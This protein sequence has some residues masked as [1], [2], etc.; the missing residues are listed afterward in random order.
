MTIAIRSGSDSQ[1]YAGGSNFGPWAHGVPDRGWRPGP[2]WPTWRPL[3]AAT[4]ATGP[5]ADAGALPEPEALRCQ[6]VA[7][8]EKHQ[9]NVSYVARDMSKARMQARRW[10]Q[11]FGIDPK[12]YRG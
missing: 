7:L 4:P 6:L 1:K 2:L 10:M 3:L 8:L 9:G 11:R 5:D 12:D